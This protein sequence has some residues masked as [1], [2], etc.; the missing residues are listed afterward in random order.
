MEK[1][2]VVLVMGTLD[3]KPEEIGFLLNCLK[4]QQIKTVLM[5]GGILGSPGL[6]ADVSRE[7]VARAADST[8]EAMRNAG[9]EGDAI[10]VMMEGAARIA[11][12]L[13]E[14]GRIHGII[15]LGGSMGTSLATAA[16]RALPFGIPKV[17]ITTM[18][19]RDTHP[20]VGTRDIMMLHSVADL[21]GLNRITRRV[22]EN[23][24]FAFTGMVK[25]RK[26]EVDESR[27]LV[28]ITTLG[29]IEVC[30]QRLRKRLETK[31]FEVVVFSSHGAGG[32]AM[33]EL[34]AE[35]RID[36]VIDLSTHELMNYLAG[37]ASSAGP[38]R[39]MAAIRRNIPLI[40]APGNIDFFVHGPYEKTKALFPDRKLHVHNPGITAIRANAKDL[41]NLGKNMAEKLNQSEGPAAVVIPKRGFSAFDFP[42]GPFYDP[43]ADASFIDTL[44]SGLK[45]FVPVIEVDA[46]INDPAFSD[47]VFEVFMELVK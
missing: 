5:D 40:V 2:N 42:G 21:I 37:G 7:E 20:F 44:K 34:I 18:G 30:V 13:F 6:A 9:H 41:E 8:I 22:I 35:A 39:L 33:E 31:G 14:S 29:S 45:E 19:S 32:K 4:Q 28:S 17:M 26:S 43:D 16:M 1:N 3:T 47:K 11:V 27:R 15:G 36:M 38:D 23:G 46:H 12:G 10:A 25:C 24:A